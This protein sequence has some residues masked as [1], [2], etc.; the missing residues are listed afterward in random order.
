MLPVSHRVRLGILRH[1]HGCGRGL[2][3][4]KTAER[5]LCK[6]RTV[7]TVIDSDCQPEI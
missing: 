1:G 5:E 7:L 2:T 4:L 3:I 6:F